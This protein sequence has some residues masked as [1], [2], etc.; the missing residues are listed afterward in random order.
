[1]P[2][3]RVSKA[4]SGPARSPRAAEY[5]V[6][7]LRRLPESRRIRLAALMDKSDEGTLT[8]LEEQ[9]LKRLGT[10]VDTL[11]LANSKTLARAV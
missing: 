2:N 5:T 1:M 8:A 4:S 9:E 11:L 10:E 6:V 7:R 3:R